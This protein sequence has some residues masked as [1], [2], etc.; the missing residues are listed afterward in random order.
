MKARCST[1]RPPGRSGLASQ[2]GR[3]GDLELRQGLKLWPR[4]DHD[5]AEIVTRGAACHRRAPNPPGR[6]PPDQPERNPTWAPSAC[7]QAHDEPLMP[8]CGAKRDPVSARTCRR[9]WHQAA[10]DRQWRPNQHAWRSQRSWLWP[11]TFHTRAAT[12]HGRTG[13]GR[14]TDQ[15]PQHAP[16]RARARDLLVRVR[17]SQTLGALER[18]TPAACATARSQAHQSCTRHA[19]EPAGPPI[20]TAVPLRAPPAPNLTWGPL[21]SLVSTTRWD[22]PASRCRPRSAT[23]PK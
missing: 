3:C 17:V 13:V 7:G 5:G 22:L 6:R 16:L 12:P 23:A 2:R 8:A 14:C 1:Q 20:T 15:R 10:I 11:T 19:C 9:D 4:A 18:R 21:R